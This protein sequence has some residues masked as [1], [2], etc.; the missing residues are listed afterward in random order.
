MNSRH[1]FLVLYWNI[2]VNLQDGS[3]GN[4]ELIAS[5][6]GDIIAQNSPDIVGLNEVFMSP[7]N[8]SPIVSLLEKVG[9]F[10]HFTDFGYLSKQ[11]VMGSVF[12]SKNK[13]ENITEHKLGKSI[14]SRRPGFNR[15]EPRLIE[16]S[17]TLRNKRVTFIVAHLLALMPADLKVHLR[18]RKEF[19]KLLA[20]IDNKNMIVGGD[21]NEYKYLSSILGIPHGFRRKTGTF[22]SP[23]WRL[24]GK[25]RNIMFA[26]FDN[27]LWRGHSDIE[28]TDFKVLKMYPSDHA[29][30][31]GTFTIND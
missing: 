15:F 20:D 9:Y 23:T 28:L 7:Q 21:F 26:N 6:L 30:M 18:Q 25:S 8:T 12:A 19:I 17:V 3:R 16:A 4:G 27:L 13:I 5:R 10:V 2:W 1:T 14:L 24:N 31:L 11:R 22:L 29:P